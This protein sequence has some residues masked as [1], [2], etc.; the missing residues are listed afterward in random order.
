MIGQYIFLIIVFAI[1]CGIL[2]QIVSTNMESFVAKEK[3]KELVGAYK[4]GTSDYMRLRNDLIDSTQHNL[5]NITS[6]K[7]R[8]GE[9]N[10]EQK[11]KGALNNNTL[12][13]IDEIIGNRKYRLQLFTT[14]PFKY[15]EE[16]TE[17]IGTFESEVNTK[18]IK[19]N[20]FLAMFINEMKINI[21]DIVYDGYKK[22][23][24]D[25]VMIQYSMKQWEN[26]KDFG[27]IVNTVEVDDEN[28]KKVKRVLPIATFPFLKDENKKPYFINRVTLLINDNNFMDVQTKEA[29]L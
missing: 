21:E 27:K 24:N 4:K 16:N 12:Q 10:E 22:D 8:L 26:A 29:Q 25:Y 20:T 15:F 13:K 11:E 23:N 6:K 1:V 17:V 14:I 9:D 2:F 18:L 3:I 7:D 5:N 19:P 28:G